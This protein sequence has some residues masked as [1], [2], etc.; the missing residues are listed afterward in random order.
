MTGKNK[1]KQI[2]SS[3]L[4]KGE[5]KAYLLVYL[6]SLLVLFQLSAVS[7]DLQQTL[8]GRTKEKNIAHI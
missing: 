6:N 4:T 8:V 5:M 1:L 3:E 7:P 2:K